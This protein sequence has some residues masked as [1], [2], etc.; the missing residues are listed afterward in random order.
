MDAIG[1]VHLTGRVV[2]TNAF[3]VKNPVIAGALVDG[4][5]GFVSVGST[6]VVG[7]LEPNASAA[8]DILVDYAPYATFRL[9]CAGGT[10]VDGFSP[11]KNAGAHCIR[12]VCFD[13]T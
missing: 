8:F 5:G 4:S 2:N 7:R 3:P 6:S 10:E 1:Y 9:F 12:R 13:D 11:Q